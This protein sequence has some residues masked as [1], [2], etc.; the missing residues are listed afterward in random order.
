MVAACLVAVSSATG[1]ATDQ[2][3]V[4]TDKGLVA[5]K[6]SDD[7]AIREFL[8]IP[9][10]QSP[11]GSLRWKPPQS[12]AKWKA[13]LKANEFG[14]RCIQSGTYY[15]ILFRDA[16]ESEDCLT[17]NVWAPAAPANRKLPVMVWFYGGG[18]NMGGSSEARQDGTNLA[19]KGV[20]VVSMNYRLGIFGFYTHR[21]LSAESQNHVSGNYGLLDQ[22]AALE[23]VRRNISAFGGDP[24]SV[25]IFGES[26]GSSA[27]SCHMV[28]PLSK[29]LFVRA[30]GESG[31]IF[32]RKGLDYPPLSISEKQNEHFAEVAFGTTSL[33]KLRSLPAEILVH[34]ALGKGP[35][36]PRFQPVIDGYFFPEDGAAI[37]ASHRQSDVSLLAGWNRD[38][39][40][41]QV[42]NS[43]EKLTVSGLQATAKTDFGQR[44]ADFAKVYAASNDQQSTRAAEDYASDKF[45]AYAT[46]AW[47]EA[48]AQT[49]H[50]PVYRYYFAMDQPGDPLHSKSIGTFHS[51][52]IEYV[53][54]NLDSRNG[55][56]WR[57]EDYKLS[58]E[59]QTYWTN[60][61][62]TG[63]P[64]SPGMPPWPT[65]GAQTNWQVMHLG[66]SSRAEPDTLRDRFL[67][68]SSV[69]KN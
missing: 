62:K 45:I 49:G 31:S 17:L 64:N 7:G 18:F 38:E 43:P 13:T 35:E 40:T 54:G 51:D 33:E 47:L 27:V 16:G 26:A 29:G 46:W 9:Y 5:G 44:A 25:T 20:I 12:A 6:L 2:P 53:F 59:M 69:W 34:A 48:Q 14:K 41:N 68:L 63:D 60:F 22:L 42:I 57:L 52:D 39:G 58:E 37:F 1:F 30:I 67:F 11:L 61:A 50:A 36:V 24:K 19:R 55:A 66:D 15:D 32:K 4:Q 56:V 8:G 28:S 21:E 23:W 3:R 65:Y 10:A